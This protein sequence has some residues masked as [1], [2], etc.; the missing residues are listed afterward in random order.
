[1]YSCVLCERNPNEVMMEDRSS[2]PSN[3]KLDAFF[4]KLCLVYFPSRINKLYQAIFL[5]EKILCVKAV[6]KRQD[7]SLTQD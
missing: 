2:R 1:M 7:I 6:Q 3:A 5:L 4:P